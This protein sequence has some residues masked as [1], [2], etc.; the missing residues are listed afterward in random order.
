MQPTIAIVAPGN[1]GAGIAWVL[2][3]HGV[4]VRTN[5]DGRGE[6]SLKRAQ[7]ARMQDVPLAALVEVDLLLSILPPAAA[8]PF[9]QRLAPLLLAAQSKPVFVDCNAKSPQSA[10][11]MAAV[12]E[13]TG[14]P[15]VDGAIIGLPPSS[16][17]SSPS[18]AVGGVPRLFAAGERAVALRVLGEHGLDVRV[19]EGPVGAAAALKMSFAGIN[20]GLTAVASAMILAATRAGAAPALREELQER[21]PVLS[22]MLARQVPDMLPKAYRWI[23]EMREISEFA[24]GD[25]AARDMYLAI[26]ALFSQI[27]S[28]VER[29]G[30]QRRA[31]AGF[32]SI[33]PG[34]SS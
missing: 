28:D 31:L 7:A 13:G 3:G 24:N 11:E 17:P 6:A 34:D 20:K 33:A 18:K 29:D 30:P 16:V 8:L 23:A 4:P 19:L 26:S 32:F 9:A 21:W 25:P 2:A 1:M 12:I 5:L 22:E 27:A 14:T 10:R 15:F